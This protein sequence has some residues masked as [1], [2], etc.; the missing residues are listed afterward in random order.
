MS[1]ARD[2]DVTMMKLPGSNVLIGHRVA[3]KIVKGAILSN[4]YAK[5]F[6]K[7]L[8][9]RNSDGTVTQRILLFFF[10]LIVCNS[11]FR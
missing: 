11:I 1:S 2:N 3:K 6:I 7:L 8:L 9:F 5:M 4:R 10:K